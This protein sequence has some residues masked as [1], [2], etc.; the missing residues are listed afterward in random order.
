MMCV[1]HFWY[2]YYV[3]VLVILC[4]NKVWSWKCALYVCCLGGGG[5][6]IFKSRPHEVTFQ[7][8]SYSITL[9]QF[10]KVVEVGFTPLQLSD[11]SGSV[12]K[13]TC[14]SAFSQN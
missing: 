7:S 13:P 14:A 3:H 1:S 4:P 10:T 11:S 8:L 9:T 2:Y 12:H 6:V 5:L